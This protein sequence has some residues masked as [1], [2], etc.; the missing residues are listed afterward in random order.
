MRRRNLLPHIY[1]LL[2]LTGAAILAGLPF[3]LSTVVLLGV[4]AYSL[5]RPPAPLTFLLLTLAT[6][7]FLPLGV[8]AAELIPRPFPSLLALPLLP[9]VDT[10]VRRAAQATASPGFQQGWRPTGLSKALAACALL[11]AAAGALASSPTVALSGGILLAYLLA[12]GALAW[13]SLRG[14]PLRTPRSRVRALVG[15]RVETTCPLKNEGTSPLSVWVTTPHPWAAVSPSETQLQ[16]GQEVLLQVTLTPPL[17][18]PAALQLQLSLLDPHGILLRCRTIE[19]IELRITP[20]ARYAAWLARRYLQETAAG[21]APV[22]PAVA[23]LLK[24]PRRGIEYYGARAYQPG[25]RLKD[26]DWK[27][28]IKLGQLVI[29]EFL[30]TP[31]EAAIL[32]VALVGR[33]PTEADTL[34]HD[35]LITALTLAREEIPIAIAAYNYQ[36]V[37]AST[38]PLSPREAVQQ[39]LSLCDRITLVQRPERQWHPVDAQRLRRTLGQLR[40]L[41]TEPAQKL[42]GILELELQVLNLQARHDPAWKALQQATER[43]PPPAA[44]VVVAPESYDSGVLSLLVERLRSKGH[45]TLRLPAALATARR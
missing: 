17:A 40:T 33:D 28:T 24:G 14:W 36:D 9:I 1:V 13:H 35:L 38:L 16:P 11:T 18:G 4:W 10:A 29:R 39:A 25:D 37:L 27:H 3:S 22:A 30:E 43:I 8:E 7:V 45:R 2:L 32:A 34:A 19:A 6:L 44:V 15:D 5:Y 26:L 31:G 23:R 21:T 42:Q 41:T 12:R 20:R